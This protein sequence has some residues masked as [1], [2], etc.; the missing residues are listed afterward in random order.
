MLIVQINFT[1][2]CFGCYES[3][4]IKKNNMHI[5]VDT[6]SYSTKHKKSCTS[7]NPHMLYIGLKNMFV[8]ESFTYNMNFT[9][10]STQPFTVICK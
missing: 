10:F 8:Y 3:K 7:K 5:V 9:K 2:E 4:R 6:R 1:K